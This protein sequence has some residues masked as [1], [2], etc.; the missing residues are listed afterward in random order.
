MD[1]NKKNNLLFNGIVQEEGETKVGA[2]NVILI[3]FL[4]FYFLN[5]EGISG[6]QDDE[7]FKV[8]QHQFGVSNYEC[9]QTI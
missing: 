7:D 2:K 9:V 4:N 8:A 5:F 3:H 6:G 1:S